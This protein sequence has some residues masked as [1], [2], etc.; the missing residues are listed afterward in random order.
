MR[1]AGPRGQQR[2]GREGESE[3]KKE[4]GAMPDDGHSAGEESPRGCK[5][6]DELL[7]TSDPHRGWHGSPIGGELDRLEP[8]QH[9][10]EAVGL[11]W[12]GG[13]AG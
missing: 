3:E 12:Q 2:Q 1:S 7:L 10:S 9:V 11:S 8:Q 5:R 4:E 13:W 6:G